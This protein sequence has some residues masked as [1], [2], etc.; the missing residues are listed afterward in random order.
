MWFF[1]RFPAAFPPPGPTMSHT[2]FSPGTPAWSWSW[3]L[4]LE[5]LMELEL[6]CGLLRPLILWEVLVCWSYRKWRRRGLP[7]TQDIW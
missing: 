6:D 3:D 1:Q 7:G 4:E 5:L 2:P